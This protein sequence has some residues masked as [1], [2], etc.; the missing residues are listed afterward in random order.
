MRQL[1]GM[2]GGLVL[3]A[4]LPAVVLAGGWVVVTLD[5]VP[6]S[7]QAGKEF[8]VGF[9]VRQH[10]KTPLE[11]GSGTLVF[12]HDASGEQMSVQTTEEGQAGHYTARVTLPREGTWSWRIE[13][14]QTH[15]MPPLTAGMA[16]APGAAP[17]AWPRLAGAGALI[18]LAL[19]CLTLGWWTRPSDRGRVAPEQARS[20]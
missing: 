9:I 4:L 3:T 13:F 5:N 6:Q 19:A 12:Q 20:A 15:Q 14:W 8:T 1:I 16:V 7:I 2:L 18:G 10:G 17:V 11:G